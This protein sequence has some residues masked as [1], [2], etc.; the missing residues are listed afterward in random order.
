[1]DKSFGAGPWV[2][3]FERAA[4]DLALAKLLA[5]VLV[6]E[7][8]HPGLEL[9]PHPDDDFGED[10]VGLEA[11]VPAEA[12]AAVTPRSRKRPPRRKLAEVLKAEVRRLAGAR[13]E[14]EMFRE[15]FDELATQSIGLAPLSEESPGTWW[16]SM[17]GFARS[18]LEAG[19]HSG[20]PETRKER[21]AA[22]AVWIRAAAALRA[23][24]LQAVLALADDA[25]QSRAS[26]FD[27]K[28]QRW[29]FNAEFDGAAFR[30]DP[31][32][33][34]LTLGPGPVEA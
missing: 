8:A 20:Y 12:A 26:L 2:F 25:W 29:G 19:G 32:R 1:V 28:L 23:D 34:V 10:E 24:P 17:S 33:F 7:A 27:S 14:K 16:M 3:S 13:A 31:A 30:A 6:E 5:D 18:V 4:Y 22:K 15:A 21:L 9:S 11:R